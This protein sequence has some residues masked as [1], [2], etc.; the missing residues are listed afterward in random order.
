M[1]TPLQISRLHLFKLVCVEHSTFALEIAQKEIIINSN[2]E[3][4]TNDNFKV[5][6]SRPQK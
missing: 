3:Y 1:K 2:L 4:L 5:F 6:Q